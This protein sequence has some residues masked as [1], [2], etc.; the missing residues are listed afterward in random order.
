MDGNRDS[1]AM[2]RSVN[3]YMVPRMLEYQSVAVDSI[4][5]ATMTSTAV[6]LAATDAITQALVAGGSDPSAI[7]AFQV[8]ETKDGGAETIDV[9]VLVVGMGGSGIAAAVSAAEAQTEGGREVSVLAI[10]KAGRYGGTSAFCGG[11]LWP[12]TPPSS[13]KSSTMARTTWTATPLRLLGRLHR[14]RRQDGHRQEV[15]G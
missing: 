2:V 14:R 5:G 1:V 8:P 13:R 6:K 9:D 12:S 11:A 7:S 4:S 3:T 15:P 10:D